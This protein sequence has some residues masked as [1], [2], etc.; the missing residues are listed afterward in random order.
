MSPRVFIG[1]E[2]PDPLRALLEDVASVLIAADARWRSEKWVAPENLHITACFVG[3]V[4]AARLEPLVE[5]VGRT[6]A[7]AEPFSL[8]VEGIAARPDRRAARMLWATV[9]DGTGRALLLA[10]SLS[11]A[12]V[13]P[14]DDPQPARPWVPHITLCRARRPRPIGDEALNSANARIERFETGMS[15]PH[16][17]VFLSRLTP[18]GPIYE[19][20]ATCALGGGPAPSPGA[21]AGAGGSPH[22]A[23]GG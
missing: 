15:V 10:R 6:C 19:R 11:E 9:E 17:T 4:P 8:A 12:I 1:F 7:Q 5:L 23:H 21:G 2:L 18:A 20:L 3:E 16:A 13:A 14:P 22:R